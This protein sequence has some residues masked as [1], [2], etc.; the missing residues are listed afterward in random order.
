[1]AKGDIRRHAE[2]FLRVAS[3]Y[4]YVVSASLEAVGDAEAVL[5]LELAVELP[6]VARLAGQSNNGVQAVESVEVVLQG[7]YP[8]RCP[9]FRLRSD[10]PSAMPHLAPADGKLAP[11]P[12]LVDGSPD[13]FFAQHDLAGR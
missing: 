3:A 1:V 13:E 11:V 2:H 6:N 10:F 5:T 9:S 8:R 12:C 7:D 4:P